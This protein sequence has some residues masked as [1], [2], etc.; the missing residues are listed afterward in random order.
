MT[1]AGIVAW[2]VLA[3]RAG[4]PGRT[5]PHAAPK[6]ATLRPLLILVVV[7]RVALTGLVAPAGLVAGLGSGVIELLYLPLL[8]ASGGGAGSPG[9]GRGGRRARLREHPRAEQTAG[10]AGGAGWRPPLGTAV[11]CRGGGRPHRGDGLQPPPRRLP[12]ASP[13]A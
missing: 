12:S 2:L 3:I 8:F 11:F 7:P 5:G 6:L 4:F 1:L 9:R 10:C 13:T